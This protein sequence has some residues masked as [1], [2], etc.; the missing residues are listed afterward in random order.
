MATKKR[1]KKAKP[2]SRGLSAVQVSHGS[3]NDKIKKLKKIVEHD[4]GSIVGVYQD[5]IGKNWQLLAALP[6]SLVEPTPFQR[7]VSEP[8][9]KRLAKNID[10]L[11]RFLDP[12]T[13]VRNEQGVY[14]TPNGHHRLSALR[15]LGARSIVAMVLPDIDVVYQIL[16]L[17]TEKA[18][19]IREKSLEA[20]RLARELVTLGSFTEKEF[21]G[22]F[23]EPAFLT[24]GACYEQ[25]GNF[26]GGAYHPLLKKIESF[27]RGKLENTIQTREQRAQQLLELDKIVVDVVKRLKSKGFESPYL[28]PFVIARINPLRFR[29]AKGPFD[30]TIAKM[31]RSAEK[32]DTKKIRADQLARSGGPPS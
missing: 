3:P 19:N 6:T 28:K 20:I 5:P 26:S 8:H 27:L 29:G 12:I 13:V 14:W 16:A 4:G 2:N 30:E 17:N 31:K 10:R 7:D 18:Y 11:N 15:L 25:K 21:E 32:F 23:E 22:E 1:L 9:V 24:L